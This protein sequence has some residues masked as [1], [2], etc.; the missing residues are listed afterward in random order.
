M[1][2]DTLRAMSVKLSFSFDGAPNGSAGN[3]LQLESPLFQILA[4]IHEHGSIGRGAQAL[5]LSY[6]HVWGAL[7]ER[8]QIFGEALVESRPGQSARLSALGERLLWAERRAVARLLPTAEAIAARLDL[9][10]LLAAR[11]DL[12][13]IA[14][15]ASHDLL[16]AGLRDCLRQQAEFLLDAEYAGSTVA[17]E[18]LNDAVCELAGIHLPLAEE[19]LCQRSGRIHREIGRLLRLGDHKLIR[20][21]TREQ[22][23][24][25]APGVAQGIDGLA[26]VAARGLEFINRQA[27]SGTRLLL[28]ALLDRAGISPMAIRGFEREEA[29]HL[30]VA[31]SVAA[32]IAQ[33]GFG[34][35]AA[36]ARFEL[37]F[38]P[39]VTED[40]FIVCRKAGL[41]SAPV[42]AVIAAL[43]SA[44][45]AAIVE[46]LPGYS[47]ARS[48]EIISLRRTL[49]WYK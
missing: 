24:M 36:A 8:E 22:G 28:E 27:G 43:R 45:F 1:R 46:A 13:R 35:H 9:E 38:L 4:A 30:S 39:L 34:L 12:T 33:C 16:I 7:K 44:A 49:P 29:T 40:Y 11:P 25:F 41:D 31:A 32:G 21:A 17:L 37:D 19:S 23:L 42:Q 14:L 2:G 3:M 47:A 5:G 48:G 20:M 18:R 15:V 10:L 6:R 26:D